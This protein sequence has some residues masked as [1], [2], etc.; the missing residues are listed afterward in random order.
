LISIDDGIAEKA[1]EWTPHGCRGRGQVNNSWKK[2]WR[3][4]ELVTNRAGGSWEQQGC[5]LWLLPHWE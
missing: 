2:I 1:L 4:G 5:G 3:C